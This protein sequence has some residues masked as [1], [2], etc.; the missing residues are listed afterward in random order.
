MVSI[1][2]CG[3][4]ALSLDRP[5]VMGILNITPDSFSDGGQFLGVDA[6]LQHAGRMV[7]AGASIIDVGGESTRPGAAQVSEQDE[8]ERVIPVV[9]A[10]AA[11]FDVVV[12]IDTSKAGVM[13]AA[14]RAGAGL[15]ND[16][17]ALQNP[18]ALTA[19]VQTG[20]PVCLM[21]MKGTPNSMQ[22]DPTYIDV[23]DEVLQFLQAR[24]DEAVS[25]GVPRDQIVW[26]PGFGFG[27]TTQ[28][29]ICLLHKLQTFTDHASVL[30]GLS[31]K[32]MF[33]EVLGNTEA[34]R[35]IASVT[36]AVLCVQRGAAI[37]RVH[38]VA[39]TIDALKVVR[40]VEQLSVS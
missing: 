10:V 14:A 20:L 21:H 38:D 23:V 28:H 30:T 36:G 6:A 5:H 40:A 19:A 12:S 9:E 22:V 3:A 4:R 24:S 27:K 34:D 32:R 25:A 26:D 7:A 2:R 29:N 18:G 11:Q 37:V 39:Q 13:R 31:R 33:G 17:R 35:T 15:I 8:I 16:V 1:L